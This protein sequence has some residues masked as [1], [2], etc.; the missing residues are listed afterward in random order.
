MTG[1]L[2]DSCGIGITVDARS[3]I[4]GSTAELI[5]FTAIYVLASGIS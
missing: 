2:R 1:W 4:S 3:G 5:D